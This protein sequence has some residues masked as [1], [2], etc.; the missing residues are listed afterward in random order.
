MGFLS[1]ALVP[2]S[3]RRAA[4]PVRTSK[5]ALTPRAIKRARRTLHP[6]DNAT[7]AVT[8]SLNT[9]KRRVPATIYHHG[10]CSINHRSREA[11]QRCH[12]SY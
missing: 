12:R 3:V 8:R 5:N 1:R 6:I 4:H 9:K 10:N 7:Y 11:A 2:R